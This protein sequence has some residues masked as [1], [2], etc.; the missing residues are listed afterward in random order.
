M[1]PKTPLRLLA[2]VAIAGAVV[3]T[4]M[5]APKQGG[6]VYSKRDGTKLLAEKKPM[7]A[8]VATAGFAEPLKVGEISGSWLKVSARGGAG[9]VFAGYIVEDK[10]EREKMEGVGSVDASSTTT[11]AAARPIAPAAKEYAARHNL[12]DAEADVDWVEAQAHKITRPIV[13]SYMS[14]NKKG[15]YQE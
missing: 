12:K 13:E 10:P 3:T 8:T 15:E 11:A 1:K 14:T 7:A 2:L 9:W 6:T 5:A 4:V